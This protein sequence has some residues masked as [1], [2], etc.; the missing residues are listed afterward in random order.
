[1]RLTRVAQKCKK[2]KCYFFP[3]LNF[4]SL[5]LPSS[6]INAL[7]LLTALIAISDASDEKNKLEAKLGL[8]FD[9]FD[10]SHKGSM[11]MDEMVSDLHVLLFSFYEPIFICDILLPTGYFTVLPI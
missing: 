8:I 4:S 2:S 6:R 5:F 10:F 9:A 7:S 3:L 1:M 11:T